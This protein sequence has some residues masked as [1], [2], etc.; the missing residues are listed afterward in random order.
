MA[1]EESC[2]PFVQTL[3]LN[4]LTDK[5]KTLLLDLFLSV[6]HANYECRSAH[7]LEY[8]CL[9][10]FKVQYESLGPIIFIESCCLGQ[11]QVLPSSGVE[12][13]FCQVTRI[14]YYVSYFAFSLRAIGPWV[15]SFIGSFYISQ[16][17]F[18]LMNTYAALGHLA[19]VL[20]VTTWPVSLFSYSQVLLVHTLM[21]FRQNHV[22]GYFEFKNPR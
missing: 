15:A 11:T 8:L 22:S 7:W 17:I 10:D 16:Y 13:L 1:K 2:L 18:L 4:N 3:L 19:S 9:W 5:F 14:F 20:T 21:E 6:F 12:P